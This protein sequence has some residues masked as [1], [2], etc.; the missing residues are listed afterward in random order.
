M[1]EY[2]YFLTSLVLGIGCVLWYFHY[3]TRPEPGGGDRDEP[4]E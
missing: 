1:V 4:R 2:L 3:M